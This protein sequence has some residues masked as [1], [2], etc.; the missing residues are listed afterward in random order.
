[1]TYQGG[2]TGYLHMALIGGIYAKDEGCTVDS[3]HNYGAIAA[4]NTV[5]MN[6]G[7]TGIHVAGIVGFANAPTG[8]EKRVTISDSSNH[9][10][11]TSQAARTAGILGAANACTDVRGCENRGNQLNTMPQ[12][13]GSRLGNICCFTNNGL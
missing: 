6:A 11:M 9:G 4:T 3:V 1:M 7:A 13:D 5:N 10:D 2:C 8:N 12:N